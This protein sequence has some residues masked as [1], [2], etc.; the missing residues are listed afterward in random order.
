LTR[1]TSSRGLQ[2]QADD[3]IHLLLP[4]G[5]HQDRDVRPLSKLTAHL[6]TVHR[7]QHEVQDDEKRIVTPR[8]VQA[9]LPVQGLDGVEAGAGKIALDQRGDIA[10]V[11]DDQDRLRGSIVRHRRP[12]TAS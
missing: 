8:Q 1:S 9:R 7:G 6:P 10:I 5:Q 4:R 12:F 2:R 3:P 11:L